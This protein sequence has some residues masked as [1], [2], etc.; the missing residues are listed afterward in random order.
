M[1][2]LEIYW[3][4]SIFF[5]ISIL[6]NLTGTGGGYLKVP[7]L[8]FFGYTTTAI[9]ISIAT[10]P[11][12][13]IPSTILNA[14]RKNIFYKLSFFII[15]GSLVGTILGNIIYN[16]IMLYNPIIYLIIF[17]ILLISVTFRL[18]TTKSTTN[19]NKIEYCIS[20]EYNWLNLII[21]ILIGFLGGISSSFFGLGGGL[22]VTPLLVEIYHIEMHRSIGTSIFVMN[23][24]A[25]FVIIENLIFGYYNFD[26]FIIIII[27]GIG[28]IIGSVI[29]SIISK[30]TK[31]KF[32][33][34]IFIGIVLG[35]AIPLLWN[36][37]L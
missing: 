2:G 12:F 31:S 29:G 8:Q 17:T 33:K 6:S 14:K 13:S 16:V 20:I 35:L 21:A 7:F 23:F 26:L 34:Y 37:Y 30:R 3:L 4:L 32:L 15:I 1:I 11:F 28:M 22:I 9:P 10:V 36:S 5:L 25:L 18:Y 19:K 27:I 24:T